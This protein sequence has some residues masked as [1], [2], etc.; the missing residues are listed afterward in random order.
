VKFFHIIP[1]AKYF[2]KILYGKIAAARQ[3][4]YSNLYF[5]QKMSN[6]AKCAEKTANYA[7]QL[8]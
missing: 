1:P 2:F 3:K 5:L 4:D 6:F 7:K 8:S